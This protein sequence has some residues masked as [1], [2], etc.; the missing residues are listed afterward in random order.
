[1]RVPWISRVSPSMTEAWPMMLS[2]AAVA[3]WTLPPDTDAGDT[4][5]KAR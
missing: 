5:S 2:E 1:M 3:D 4:R